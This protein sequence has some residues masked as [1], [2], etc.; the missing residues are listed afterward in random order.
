MSQALNAPAYS[1]HS[2]FRQE[3]SFDQMLRNAANAATAFGVP[4]AIEGQYP[5]AGDPFLVSTWKEY[6]AL[7]HS[8]LP[9]VIDLSHLNIL[10]HASG[11]RR[12]DL[13]AQM[14]GHPN[15]LEV[16][17]SSNDG[18]GDHHQQC[19]LATRRMWWWPLLEAIHANAVVF[20]E[21]NQLRQ[22]TADPHLGERN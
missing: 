21:G 1:A 12:D 3:A 16:H 5:K 2:G 9:F 10:V 14:L 19:K 11:E 6:E 13:V 17:V 22:R 7:M 8:G 20:T 18:T 15:C 4:V